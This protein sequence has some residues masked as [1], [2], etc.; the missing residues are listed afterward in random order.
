MSNNRRV[1]ELV[2]NGGVVYRVN[3]DRVEVVVCGRTSP[4]I[5]GL[6]KG[7]PDPGESREETALR[8]VNAVLF[9]NQKLFV[10][11]YFHVDLSL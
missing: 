2:S 5:W 11:T 7:T 10:F 4:P 8:E 1:I 6:P 9:K 3:E